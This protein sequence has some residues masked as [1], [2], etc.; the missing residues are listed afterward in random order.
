M[1]ALRLRLRV[2][3][4]QGGSL[5]P[6]KIDLL[7]S[8]ARKGSLSGAARELRMSYRRA[9]L[10]LHSVNEAFDKPAVELSVGGR[11]GGGAELTPFGTELIYAYRNL[12]SEAQAHARERFARIAQR[13]VVVKS[14]ARQLKKVTPRPK[15][16]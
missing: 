10:L 2:D 4:E 9:W 14:A 15:L 7:E 8:I 12:E 6:G 5:G 13:R 3:F 11:Q 1:N 16:R